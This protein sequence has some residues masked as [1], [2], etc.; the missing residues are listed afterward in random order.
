MKNDNAPLPSLRFKGFSEPWQEKTLGEIAEI[1][2]GASPRPIQDPKW[3][4]ENSTVG[5]LRIADV[6]EQNGR[7]YHLEQKLS[8]LGQEKTRVLKEKHLLLSIAATVGKPVINYIEIGV[9]DGF[10]IFLNPKFNQ[11]F[12]FQWLDM[13]KDKWKQY[14]QPGSQINLNSDLVKNQTILIPSLAEQEKI[15]GV[16]SAADELISLQEQKITALKRH[17]QALMQ[18]LFPANGESVPRLRFDG[19]SEPWQEKTLGEIGEIITGKTP[20]TKNSSLWNGDIQ[21]VTPTDIKEDKYQVNTERT[22]KNNIKYKILPTKSIMFTCI[23]STIGKIALSVNECITN[24]QINSIIP[25]NIF[26]NEF[27][28]YSLF[29]KIPDIKSIASST[30]VPIINKNEFSKLEILVP[31]L[32]EQEKIAGVFSSADELISLHQQKLTTLKRHKQALMQR[33]FPA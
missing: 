24:Q 18:Q 8:K 15:A 20:D 26:S 19:F 29:Q 27:I 14:G 3:F 30:A 4:D 31:S 12:M 23:G 7:I 6:T 1:V 2:R 33:L 13:F 17:K 9:H 21:F 32:A 16:L 22:I 10:I 5:W 11:E 28:Y 25:Y